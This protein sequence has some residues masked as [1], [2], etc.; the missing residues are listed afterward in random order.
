MKKSAFLLLGLLFSGC[1]HMRSISTT[2]I[3]AARDKAIQAEAYRFLFLLIN[4]NNQYVDTLTRDLAQ[5]CPDGRVEGIL[6]KQEDIVYFPFFAHAVRVTATGFCV[7][8]SSTS[9]APEPSPAVAPA[10]NEAPSGDVE[11]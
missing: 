1:V 10:A 3:P 6:T 9:S 2:S 8:P 4:F 5:Q 11:K 7:T